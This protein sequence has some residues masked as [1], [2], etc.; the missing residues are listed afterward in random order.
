[1]QSLLIDMTRRQIGQLKVQK[2]AG[3]IVT[4]NGTKQTTWQCKCKCGTSVTVRASD[5][6]RLDG[7][8]VLS[9]RSC[10]A[11][12]HGHTRPG[13]Q[14][15]TYCAWRSMIN[16]CRR[17][18]DYFDRGI[19]VCE[20]WLT[21]AN[22]LADMGE[23]K[24]KKL[25]IDRI[26]NDRGYEPGNC[27]WA[28]SYVQCRNKRSNVWITIN[29][30]K[31]ILT[32][33]RRAV[34]MSIGTYYGRTKRGMSPVEAITAT[35]DVHRPKS[36]E[37]RRKLSATQPKALTIDQK[38]IVIEMRRSGRTISAIAAVFKVGETTIS[39]ACESI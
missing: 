3:V 11:F 2:R 13:W 9:C 30:R 27:R 32:D 33:W 22:F 5:L 10:A 24:R 4:P 17:C 15:L 19:T 39:R 21:F 35:I 1:M 12:R 20:R 31:R 29:G 37:H 7:K 6:R 36:D 16:R 28:T 14:S 34:G 18:K 26:D 23:R 8:R 25:T 38:A